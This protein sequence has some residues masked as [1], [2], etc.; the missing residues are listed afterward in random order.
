MRN[1]ILSLFAATLSTSAAYSQTLAE[2][3]NLSNTSSQ[4]TARSIGF[5]NALGSIGADFSVISVNPAGLGV[6]RTSELSFTPSLRMNYAKSTFQGNTTSD[7]NTQQVINQFGLILTEAPKGKRYDHRNWK[8][9]AFAVGMNRIAD[10]NHDYNYNGNN[11]TSSAGLLFEADVNGSADNL[12]V[13]GSLAYLGDKTRLFTHPLTSYYTSV[14]FAGGINQSSIIRERGGINEY[15][16]SLGGNYKE[17]IMLGAAIGVPSFR[18]QR[19]TDYTETVLP[20]NTNNPDNFTTFT[21]NNDITIK[22]MGFNLKI[23]AI[24]KLTNFF[25]IGAAFHTPTFYSLNETTDYGVSSLVGGKRYSVSTANDLPQ[26]TF[27]YT[28]NTPYRGI[29]SASVVIKQLGFVTA[30]YEL[31]DYSAMQYH[32]YSGFNPTAGISAKQQEVNM[33]NAIRANYQAASNLRLGAEI[34]FSKYFMVRGGVGY[35]GNPYKIGP[36]MERIDLSAGVGFRSKHFF[37]DFGVV[38]SS[39]KFSEQAYGNIDYTHVF[40]ANTGAASPVAITQPVNNNVAL[41]VG[42]KF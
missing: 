36:A 32:Y 42:L 23:G 18:Y 20:T 14:P 11:F 10:F 13:P 12:K 40:T 5:G 34:K 6:Y 39:Y 29:L 15:V 30:N 9:A 26:K 35:Y 38:N 17:R 21:Q 2:A 33:N 22:G 4:G 28:F 8:A 25:R 41:S 19:T 7:N 16:V 37:A 1:F 31:V 3:F 24:L 27:E